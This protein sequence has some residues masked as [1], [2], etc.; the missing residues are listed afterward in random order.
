MYVIR[1]IVVFMAVMTFYGPAW[2]AALVLDCDVA[3]D[4]ENATR[5]S[6]FLEIDE[7]KERM[8]VVGADVRFKCDFFETTISCGARYINGSPTITLGLDRITGWMRY[9]W[10]DGIL[11]WNRKSGYC[12]QA[13]MKKKLF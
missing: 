6:F 2:A 5:Q 13:T 11:N 1:V 12:K 9:S 3:S 10:Y 4:K 8:T 7:K